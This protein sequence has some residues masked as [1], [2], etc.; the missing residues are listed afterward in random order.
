MVPA[1]TQ[2]YR[3]EGAVLFLS[4]AEAVNPITIPD[5]WSIRA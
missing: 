1:L 4:G 5:P 2:N 3:G